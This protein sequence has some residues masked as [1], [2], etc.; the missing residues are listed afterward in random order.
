MTSLLSGVLLQLT[1]SPHPPPPHQKKVN[2][3]SI[4]HISVVFEY[5]EDTIVRQNIHHYTLKCSKIKQQLHGL[6]GTFAEIL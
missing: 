5:C 1:Q 4:F 6:G 2:C 3:H